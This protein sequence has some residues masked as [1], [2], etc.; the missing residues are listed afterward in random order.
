MK[1]VEQR[2]TWFLWK[3]SQGT[4]GFSPVEKVF[5]ELSLLY[6]FTN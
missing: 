6:R 2:K 5:K 4:F 1:K 3:S